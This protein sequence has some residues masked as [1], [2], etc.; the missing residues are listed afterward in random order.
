AAGPL[1]LQLLGPGTFHQVLP[2]HLL[3]QLKTVSQ[4]GLALF[5]VSLA[6]KLRHGAARPADRASGPTSGRTSG[7]TGHPADRPAGRAIGWVAAGSFLLP[8]AAGLLLAAWILGTG[9]PALRGTAP[10]PAFVLLIAVTLS[11]TAVPV[12]ARILTDR[13]MEQTA[14]G[15]VSFSAAVLLDALSWLALVAAVSLSSGDLGHLVQAL[16]ALAA[17]IIALL[18]LRLLLGTRAAERQAGRAPLAA[19]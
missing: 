3:A 8:L 19:A 2:Q 15:R 10:A 9:D 12:L 16:A 14:V 11:V 7:T 6:H 13:G 1:A 17:G 18:L 4:A 5:M